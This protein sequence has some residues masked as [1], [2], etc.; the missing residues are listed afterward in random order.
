MLV[1]EPFVITT[2][3]PNQFVSA[4]VLLAD[5]RSGAFGTP[6]LH[7][8][9]KALVDWL[10]QLSINIKATTDVYLKSV[11]ILDAYLSR[12][13]DALIK[14]ELYL[15][16]TSAL[17]LACAHDV[18]A[19]GDIKHSGFSLSD[20]NINE[21]EVF[22]EL[23]CSV[24]MP[25]EKSFLDVIFA[26]MG[27]DVSAKHLAILFSTVMTLF[28]TPYLPSVQATAC[29]YLAQRIKGDQNIVNV[30]GIPESVIERCVALI[31]RR[32]DDLERTKQG[33]YLSLPGWSD[34]FWIASEFKDTIKIDYKGDGYYLTST[35]FKP[36]LR[37]NLIS[38]DYEKGKKIGAGGYAKVRKVLY[39]GTAYAVKQAHEVDEDYL[40]MHTV[41]EIS[42]MQSLS[43]DN[44]VKICHITSDLRSIFLELGDGDLNS[45]PLGAFDEES[46]EDFAVQM[47]C[48]L[49][50]IHNC[51][52][53][54]RD[55]KP[56]N[57]IH[58][59]TDDGPIYK[60]TDF[61]LGRGCDIALR[62]GNYS[63]EVCTLHYRP[64]ELLLGSTV[65][66]DR[67]D[68]WSMM[69]VFYEVATG[70]I[71][72]QGD[73]EIGQ[74]F[75]IF[76]V[77]GVPNEDTWPG[78]TSL[79]EASVLKVNLRGYRPKPLE[80]ERLSVQFKELLEYGLVMD[81]NQRPSAE[82]LQNK[83]LEMIEEEEQ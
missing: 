49:V 58:Y 15:A 56:Q 54:H 25:T 18:Q 13:D 57:I 43:D 29:A 19:V 76:D 17:D 81:P 64:L 67:I 73:S 68:V 10:M 48:A 50:Y 21:I 45:L 6:S 16:A 79:P 12:K 40:S 83:F 36:S 55:I 52:V 82:A 59:D 60:L 30:F 51:G 62:N 44:V 11:K 53:L 78:V 63:T 5:E 66:S 31:V 70:N 34:A 65:Y 33:S 35:Y 72:F 22:K 80:D 77:L 3:A 75:K 24:S 4:E 42:I 27:P 7:S 38:P 28:N 14:R 46:Q 26:H 23:G 61:G 8:G 41:R 74:I 71:L 20:I 47:L 37:I 1:T 39:Q 32:V 9:R 2:K 69:C